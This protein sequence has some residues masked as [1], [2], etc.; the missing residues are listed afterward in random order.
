MPAR[1]RLQK[2][3]DMNIVAEHKI[4]GQPIDNKAPKRPVRPV[5]WFVIVGTLLAAL[6]GGL[7]LSLIHI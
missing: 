4:S 2:A 7:V 1:R 3:H 5:L 6:V